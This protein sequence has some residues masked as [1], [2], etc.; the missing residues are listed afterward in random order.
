MLGWLASRQTLLVL[1]N[2]EHLLDGMPALVERLLAGSP[3]L[4]V[5]LTSRA[6]LLVPFEWVFPVPGLSLDGRRRARRR[7]GAVRQAGRGGREPGGA[8]RYGAG[9]RHLPRARRHGAG[10]RADRGALPVARPGRDRGRAGRPDE[11]AGRRPPRG[12]QA[13][14][15]AVRARL[16]LRPA[17]TRRPGG[18]A[19]ALG[20]RGPV[21]R[22]RGGGRLRRLAA[23]RGRRRR[24]GAG[25][26][27]RPEPAG[28]RRGHAGDP[29]PGA[30]DRSASTAPGGWTPR[31][32]RRRRPPATWAGAWTPPPRS[33]CRRATTGPGAWRSTSWP[34]SCGPRCAGPPVTPRLSRGRTGWRSRWPS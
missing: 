27:R 7:G 3:R 4:S 23:G 1:D 31:A 9:G 26:A 21:H 19:P 11:P 16:E 17:R 24:G 25:P 12:R 6:R 14:V 30:G 32:K 13:P 33:G 29:V 15:A 28:P 18:A 2:C 5:L 20:V 10:H 22:G 34:T 8:G